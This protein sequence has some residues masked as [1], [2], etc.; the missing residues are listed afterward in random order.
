MWS[1]TER[2]D[3]RCAL[4][5]LECLPSLT[6][7]PPGSVHGRILTRKCRGCR[8]AW[9]FSEAM[10]DSTCRLI[11]GSGAG[12]AQ[13]TRIAPCRSEWS[14]RHRSLYRSSCAPGASSRTSAARPPDH[15][16]EWRWFKTCM[17]RARHPQCVTDG[18]CTSGSWGSGSTGWTSSRRTSCTMWRQASKQAATAV[19]IPSSRSSRLTPRGT[20]SW[21][22]GLRRGPSRTLRGRVAEA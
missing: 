13:S 15:Q 2:M 18:P 10:S 14:R 11:G 12:I 20:G 3:L 8:V 22:T 9:R 5:P 19:Q 4:C 21:S 6:L 7:C 16:R 1:S 17:P